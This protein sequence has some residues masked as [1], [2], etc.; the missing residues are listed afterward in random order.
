MPVIDKEKNRE[1]E[2]EAERTALLDELPRKEN[3]RHRE[4]KMYRRKRLKGKVELFGMFCCLA[5][6][7]WKLGFMVCKLEFM[8]PVSMQ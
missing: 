3:R 8:L 4:K 5:E 7:G 6:V 1:T 2:H